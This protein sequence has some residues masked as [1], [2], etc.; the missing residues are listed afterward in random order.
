MAELAHD[1]WNNGSRLPKAD[2]QMSDALAQDLAKT[3]K[4]AEYRSFKKE[5]SVRA[6]TWKGHQ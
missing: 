5:P 6:I 1:V 4:D 3:T 2:G